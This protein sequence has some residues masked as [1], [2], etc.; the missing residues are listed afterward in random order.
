MPTTQC[1]RHTI[2]MNMSGVAII[3]KMTFV[4]PGK[5]LHQPEKILHQ[6]LTLRCNE[7]SALDTYFDTHR[8]TGSLTG[9]FTGSQSHSQAHTHAQAHRLIHRFTGS[10]T[11]SQ[12]HSQAQ[13]STNNPKI[14]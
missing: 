5:I 11:G 10:H 9:S 8:L 7:H 1:L 13:K 14:N 6:L 4:I 12:A 3:G 2:S